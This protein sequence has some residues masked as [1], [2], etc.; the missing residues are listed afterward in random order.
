M[1]MSL[2]VVTIDVDP[3][4]RVVRDEQEGLLYREGDH[5]ALR[6]CIERL[7]DDAA[8]ARRLGEAG[9]RRV[10]E[11]FSWQ[12]HAERLEVVLEECIREKAAKRD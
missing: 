9:R 7:V 1:A 4:N 5:A 11:Q 12:K 3:L 10:V 2:P 6:A 8:L